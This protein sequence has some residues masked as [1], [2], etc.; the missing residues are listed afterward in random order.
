VGFD[1]PTKKLLPAAGLDAG[2]ILRPI[3]ALHLLSYATRP[4]YQDDLFDIYV[5]W[6]LLRYLG[7][8]ELAWH[9][10]HLSTLMVS[11]AGQRIVGNQRR[12]TSEEIGIGFG[13]LL[14]TRWFKATGAATGTPISIVDIDAALDDRYIYAAGSRKAVR[15][16]GARR[17]DYLIICHDPAMRGRYRVRVLECKG[18]RTAGYAIRQLASAVE[19]L[20]G[21]RVAGRIPAG[22]AVSTVSADK[23]LAS[24][25]TTVTCGASVPPLRPSR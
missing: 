7:F 10:R 24:S 16:V 12:V 3:E 1:T 21:I 20:S 22:V 9:S 14:A 17:P 5:Q 2:V 15:A 8:F 13:A 18:T 19:Q 6:G 4:R 23:G 25:W 11:E